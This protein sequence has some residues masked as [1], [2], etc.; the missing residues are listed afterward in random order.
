MIAFNINLAYR[1]VLTTLMAIH[2]NYF[3]ETLDIPSEYPITVENLEN[4]V[5]VSPPELKEIAGSFRVNRQGKTYFFGFS[6]GYLAR[7]WIVGAFPNFNNGREEFYKMVDEICQKTS[8]IEEEE[9]YQLAVQWLIQ[10]GVDTQR[11]EKKCSR[12]IEQRG[13]NFP[14]KGG[15]LS[16]M[17]VRKTPVFEI[18]WMDGMKRGNPN[19]VCTI[20][21]DGS[22]KSLI[23][24][25][26]HDTSFFLT[27][28]ITIRDRKRTQKDYKELLDN[29]E[30]MLEV[31]KVQT[32]LRED[33]DNIEEIEK[34]RAS[35]FVEQVQRQRMQDL[36]YLSYIKNLSSISDE[37]FLKMDETQKSNLILRFVTPES[38][39]PQKKKT[40]IIKQNE[41][42]K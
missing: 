9:A 12:D 40:E 11:L 36:E 32:K 42:E 35:E 18:K 20:M 13:F 8:L 3:C 21:V 37:D 29:D 4:K 38:F 22:T 15:E 28:P 30:I 41:S 14:E 27:K 10:T 25:E 2:A 5:R 23:H 16:P 7:F 26:I 6:D 34:K 19:V 39:P 17:V 24:W 1:F 33:K 31:V